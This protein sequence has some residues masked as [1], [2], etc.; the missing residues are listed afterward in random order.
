MLLSKFRPS[1]LEWALGWHI[2]QLWHI[3]EAFNMALHLSKYWE[4]IFI[5][6]S[7]PWS[8][9]KQMFGGSFLY[10]CILSLFNQTQ[11]WSLSTLVICHCITNSCC[12]DLTDVTLAEDFETEFWSRFESWCFAENL[13][14]ELIYHYIVIY[15]LRSLWWK[16]STL[17]SV[18]PLAM[19]WILKTLG[20][21]AKSWLWGCW[22]FSMEM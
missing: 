14:L 5:I 17:S 20:E 22:D 16:H 9:L 6:F 2:P 13:R 12:W 8:Q 10:F 7:S 4:K 11:V 15:D 19:F 21:C 1:P 3:L 18:A